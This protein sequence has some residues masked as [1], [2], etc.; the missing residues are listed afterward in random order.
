MA[1]SKGETMA[2]VPGMPKQESEAHISWPGPEAIE[3]GK[4]KVSGPLGAISLGKSCSVT[5]S[6]KVSG[7]RMDKYGGSIDLVTK[8]LTV[9][10]V[11]EAEDDEGEAMTDV[12][13]RLQGKKK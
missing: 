3:G 11:S 12:V 10:K 13:D 8:T 6:G 9:G 1:K 2:A 7:F 5:I 4:F